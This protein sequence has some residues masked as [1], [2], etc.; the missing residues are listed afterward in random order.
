MPSAVVPV[1]STRRRG[2]PRARVAQLA[3]A[4][5]LVALANAVP[6]ADAPAPPPATEAAALRVVLDAGMAAIAALESQAK[7]AGDEK[8]ALEV[9]TGIVQAKTDM[10]R[11]LLEVQLEWARHDGRAEKIAEIEGVL[12]R[13]QSPPTGEPQARPLPPTAPSAR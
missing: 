8:R 9:Q 4:L 2:L 11:R 12:A 10:Q 1:P 3:A 5:L 13:M 6:A 7:S